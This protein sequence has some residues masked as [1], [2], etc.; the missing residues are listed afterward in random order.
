MDG[1]V[2]EYVYF[3]GITADDRPPKPTGGNNVDD[4]E[5]TYTK[6]V[7]V[8]GNPYVLEWSDK[9]Q[10]V[11]EVYKFEWQSERKKE[12]TSTWGNFTEPIL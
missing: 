11:D 7:Y 1:S 6:T 10:G 2:Y 12:T 8:N 9:A 4:F 5:P 3:R